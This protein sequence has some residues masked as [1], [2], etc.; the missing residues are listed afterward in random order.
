VDTGLSYP[1]AFMAGVVSFVS[2]CVLPLL[3]SYITLITGLSFEELTKTSQKA[4]V[5]F[6][7]IT[8][9]FTF[10]LGFSLIF[11]LFGV[12]SSYIGSL[13][14]KYKDWIRIGGGIF[15]IIFGL[16]IAGILK[17]NFFMKEKKFYISSNPTGYI[18]TFLIGIAF[19]AGWTPC[20]GPILGSILVIATTEGS[21]IYG[22]KLLSVYSLGLALPFFLSSL[23]INT[24]LSY[25][26]KLQK[27]IK[28]ITFISGI[29]L[30]VFGIILLTNQLQSISDLIFKFWNI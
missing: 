19:A 14:F 29:T 26:K 21:T 24:F 30:F 3:P 18:S 13:F 7:T 10:I 5:R 23:L 9:S 11:I 4:N 6:L 22:I 2:P 8:H 15:L 12:S 27:Y 25:S 20:I 17:I 1:L 16:F 28:I